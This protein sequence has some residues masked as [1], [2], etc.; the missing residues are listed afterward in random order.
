MG[1]V[2]DQAQSAEEVAEADCHLRLYG[3]GADELSYSGEYCELCNTRI[4]ELGW[5]G[6]GTMGGG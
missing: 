2:E 1:E 5:C 6:C 4:D 3:K